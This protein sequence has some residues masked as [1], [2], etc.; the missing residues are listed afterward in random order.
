[1]ESDVC[2]VAVHAGGGYVDVVLPDAVAVGLLLPPLCDI[3]DPAQ[4]AHARQLCVPGMPPLDTSK[5]LAENGIRDG[6]TL[7]LTTAPA[8]T[9]L[10]PVLGTA[11][12]LVRL[13]T[14]TD[15]W[16]ASE[17]R[18][19][20]LLATVVLAAA[21]GVLAVPGPLGVPHLLLAAS[22]AGA[23][24][25][26]AARVADRG[27]AVFAAQAFG[28]A[29][30]VAATLCTS[31]LG[32][33]AHHTGLLLATV[34]AAVLV[35]AG[36]LALLLCGLSSGANRDLD[37]DPDAHHE[38]EPSPFTG[39]CLTALVLAAAGAATFGILL[40]L[41][42]PTGV[43]CTLAA[44]VAAALLLRARAQRTPPQRVALLM[45][46]T[47]IAATALV[48]VGR[49]D[50]A[51]APW[52]CIVTA[53]GTAATVWLGCRS[54]QRNVAPVAGRVATIAECAAL[55]AIIPLVCWGFGLYDTVRSVG[56][57]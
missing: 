32:G 11:E 55:A 3:V 44:A 26:I 7:L 15:P 50:T 57:P 4:P 17:S 33:S 54:A 22:A 23:A 38:A 24:A 53:A 13:T 19:A 56:L 18:T 34:S 12:Q 52:L 48:A 5:T 49:V 25:A 30:T 40:T 35:S 31:V 14:P 28:C 47:A 37:L 16:T 36:R 41:V 43:D 9:L 39:Q 1:M 46:G 2:R 8:P 10:A 27:R 20:A 45:A 6:A 29:L 21:G 42:S 51:L